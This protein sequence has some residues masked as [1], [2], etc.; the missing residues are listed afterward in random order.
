MATIAD[1]APLGVQLPDVA[2]PDADGT[3]HHL[4]EV[5]AGRPLLVGFVCNHCPYVQHIEAAL[6]ALVAGYG[7]RLAVVGVMSNDV[8]AYPQDG[9]EGMREQSVRAGWSFPYLIDTDHT[10]ALTL[11]AACTPDLFVFETAGTLVHRGAFDDSTPGN[12]RP[13][14][15]EHLRAALD[16]VLSGAP[17]PT[18][19]PPSL[20]CGIKWRP[21]LAPA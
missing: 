6:G 14:T 10:L 3:L 2:L 13:V 16:A 17:V 5:A 21:G 19:L 11:G 20:G 8:E 4:A 9:P 15:G 7:T 12:G 1:H 18:D